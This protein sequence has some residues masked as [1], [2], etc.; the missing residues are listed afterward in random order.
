LGL[1][2]TIAVAGSPEVICE[3]TIAALEDWRKRNLA[4]EL[5]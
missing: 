4:R 3:R 2:V 1:L 5:A